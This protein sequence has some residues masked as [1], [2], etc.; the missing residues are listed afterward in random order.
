MIFTRKSPITTSI[1]IQVM[2][3][4]PPPTNQPTRLL[5]TASKS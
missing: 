4:A 5:N 1:K 3:M 2:F